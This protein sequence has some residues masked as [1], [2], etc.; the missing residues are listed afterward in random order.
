MNRK[1]IITFFL[2][3]IALT[4]K[5]AMAASQN[6]FVYPFYAGVTGGHGW[7]TWNGLV[8]TEQNGAI[9]LSTPVYVSEGGKLWGLFAG[10]EFN[11]YF[12][13]EAAYMHYPDANVQFDAMSLFTF[14]NNGLSGFITHTEMISLMANIML[15]VPHS[16]VRVY[17]GAGLAEVH[18]YD[19]IKNNW[20][21]SP[22]FGA[23]FNYNFTDRLM[24]ELGANY[25]AGRGQS[26]LNPAENYFP[27]IYSIFLRLA[28]RF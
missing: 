18:R 12:A 8:P 9:N 14:E 21:P 6:K 28:L 4:T 23:G 17:S 27:F 3:V 5:Y 1:F 25:T 22:T 10:Y 16:D 20:Q 13:I 7:T 24:G 2:I 11:P 26:Q 15:I 19:I